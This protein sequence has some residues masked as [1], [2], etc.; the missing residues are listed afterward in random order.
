MF[1]DTDPNVRWV[2]TGGL[3]VLVIAA[4]ALIARSNSSQMANLAKYASVFAALILLVAVW[5]AKRLWGSKPPP[6]R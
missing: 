5:I 6:R 1:V 4:F 3:T 2:L